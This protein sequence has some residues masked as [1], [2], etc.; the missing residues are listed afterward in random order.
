MK[1]RGLELKHIQYILGIIQYN[2]CQV[3]H[4]IYTEMLYI[5]L[6]VN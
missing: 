2:P 4:V 1:Q 6:I 3:A 5:R